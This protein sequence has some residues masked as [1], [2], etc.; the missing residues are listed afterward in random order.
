MKPS[1]PGSR[2][3][4]PRAPSEAERGKFLGELAEG[5][6]VTRAAELAGIARQRAYELR[7]AD[8]EFAKAWDDALEVGTDALRD[9]L[10]RRAVEGWDEDTFDGDGKLVRRVR[11]LASNDLIAEL[12]RRD[13][14]YRESAQVQV[15][16]VAISAPTV[17]PV[18]SMPT[19]VDL[20]RFA[21]T[22]GESGHAAVIAGLLSAAEK[23]G[24]LD[25]EYLAEL[26]RAAQLAETATPWSE[27][28]GPL[29]LEAG[30]A[31]L[32]RAGGAVE[33][34]DRIIVQG[35]AS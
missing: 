25:G 6:S 32:Q 3:R 18:R 22:L 2:E 16:A 19:A 24:H 33:T 11:R 29:A 30:S 14:A 34:L 31:E 13:P 10:R 4:A 26:S 20:L 21:R 12:K 35:E 1:R 7:Q 23:R 8:P 28:P 15:A 5:W 17:E 27:H 9:E